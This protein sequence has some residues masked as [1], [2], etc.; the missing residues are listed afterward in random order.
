MSE[1]VHTYPSINE[2]TATLSL[3]DV[4]R[5]ITKGHVMF[6]IVRFYVSQFSGI[7]HGEKP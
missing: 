1:I 7:V 6:H 4:P 3:L 2:F 5:H